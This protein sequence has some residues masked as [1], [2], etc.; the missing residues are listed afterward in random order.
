MEIHF[1]IKGHPAPVSHRFTRRI[2][3]NG[4]FVSKYCADLEDIARV[5]EGNYIQDIE[6][7]QIVI[8]RNLCYKP[9]IKYEF[10]SADNSLR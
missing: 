1:Y 10:Y 4:L 5:F 9:E 7:I 6:K 3:P 2:A 8:N